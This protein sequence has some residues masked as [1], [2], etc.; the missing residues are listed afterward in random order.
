MCYYLHACDGV[1][2]I[3]FSTIVMALWR[4]KIGLVPSPKPTPTK[5]NTTSNSCEPN[6]Q[7]KPRPKP[8]KGAVHANLRLKLPLDTIYSKLKLTYDRIVHPESKCQDAFISVRTAAALH[9][10]RLP[11]LLYTWLQTVDPKQ[12]SCSVWFIILHAVVTQA[13]SDLVHQ[14]QI[15]TDLANDTWIN[16]TKVAGM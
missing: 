14:V 11:L 12:V 16:A 15:L 4:S 6:L 9:K 5:F 10:S 1:A 3:V 7:L 8:R 13:K 2:L